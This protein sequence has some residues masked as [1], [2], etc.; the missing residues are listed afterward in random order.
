MFL[1]PLK[2]EKSR[3]KRT[4]P[5]RGGGTKS[6]QLYRDPCSRS[7]L[8]WHWAPHSSPD[9]SPPNRSPISRRDMIE[10]TNTS[11][12]DPC[13]WWGR[14]RKA[15]DK[16]RGRERDRGKDRETRVSEKQTQW[17]RKMG[18]FFFFFLFFFSG[19]GRNPAGG[20][21]LNP[22]LSPVSSWLW[23]QWFLSSS[24]SCGLPPEKLWWYGSSSTGAMKMPRQSVMPGCIFIATFLV[25]LGT[26]TSV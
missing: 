7:P 10:E 9:Q 15:R 16:G 5:N 12:R 2:W 21:V 14:R 24:W 3:Q 18:G 22:A 19:G 25:H 13:L 6:H 11:P 17:E 1:P 20:R 23:G 4:T 8:M 26:L